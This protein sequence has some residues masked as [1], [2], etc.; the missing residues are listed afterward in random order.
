M[1]AVQS[2]LGSEAVSQEPVVLGW[3]DDGGY[4]LIGLTRPHARLFA[5]IA[6]ST[7]AVARQTEERAAE[8]GLP[9]TRLTTWYDVDDAGSLARLQA[10]MRGDRDCAGGI[11]S[12][13]YAQIPA[14]NGRGNAAGDRNREREC[15]SLNDSGAFLLPV[16]LRLPMP[17]C[18]CSA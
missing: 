8:L 12:G 2:L 3:S 7:E 5:E 18:C 4:Y 14:G 9:V 10:E 1:Q 6:W 17:R 11:R 16:R 13:A 15:A